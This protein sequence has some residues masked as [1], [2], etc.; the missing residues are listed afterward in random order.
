[1]LPVPGIQADVAGGRWPESGMEAQ[2][3]TNTNHGKDPAPC[4]SLVIPAYNE[5]SRIG[6]TLRH[7]LAYLDAQPYSAEVIVVD[8]GS[9]DGTGRITRAA[10]AARKNA[11]LLSH[12]TN[13]GKG[14][15]VRTGMSAA[16]GSYRVF[17]DADA[18]TPI[19][20]LE[21]LRPRFEDGA[22]IVIGSRALADSDI[23][24]RQSWYREAMGR[25]FNIMLRALALTPFRDTQCGFKGFTAPAAEVV[26]SRQTQE[27]FAFDTEI[28][29]IAAGMGLR[30][31]E[32]PVRWVNCSHTRLRPFH[33]VPRMF[34]DMLRLRLRAW[35]GSYR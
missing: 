27:G 26:F 32:V 10:F 30:I 29:F 31:D 9:V 19:E 1:M 14:A 16:R 2:S 25:I 33:H 21:K 15:A 8:D 20:E 35:R 13:R 34:L 12:H 18:S 24:V 3:D 4:L 22:D 28:L 17:Y 6:A 5:E 23:Q 11:H 7:V